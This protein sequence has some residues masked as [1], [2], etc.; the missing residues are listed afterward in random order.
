M[1][2]NQKNWTVLLSTMLAIGAVVLTIFEKNGVD[3]E[4]FCSWWP[5]ASALK[6]CV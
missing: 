3:E 2:S 6:I 1:T 4:S 5:D